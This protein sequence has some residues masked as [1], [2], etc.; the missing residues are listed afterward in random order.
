MATPPKRN[1][2]THTIWCMLLSITITPNDQV[3]RIK[4]KWNL[5]KNKLWCVRRRRRRRWPNDGDDRYYVYVVAATGSPVIMGLSA[6]GTCDCLRR[7][8]NRTRPVSTPTLR[9]PC[10]LPATA[11]VV[12]S[13]VFFFLPV[14]LLICHD[15]FAPWSLFFRLISPSAVPPPWTLQPRSSSFH[16]SY[17][18]NTDIQCSFLLKLFLLHFLQRTMLTPLQAKPYEFIV[19]FDLIIVVYDLNVLMLD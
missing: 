14:I 4:K 9:A 12:F 1:I 11:A 8:Q 13:F 19:L 7:N 5:K 3:R 10:R 17:F 16:S 2:Y 18:L 6:P 15:V